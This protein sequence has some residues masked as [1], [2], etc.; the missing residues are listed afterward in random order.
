MVPLT[1]L[2]EGLQELPSTIRITSTGIKENLSY[3]HCSIWGFFQAT[4]HVTMQTA[5]PGKNN[6]VWR[7][8]NLK[9][10]RQPSVSTQERRLTICQFKINLDMPWQGFLQKWKEGGITEYRKHE[11]IFSGGL[12]APQW[13]VAF[14]S[15][16]NAFSEH[17]KKTAQQ[18]CSSN[19]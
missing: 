15:P 17:F 14:R 8:P 19:G 2:Q 16:E 18:T 13:K 9:T 1:I 3:Y 6:L 4:R 5:V 12:S 7:L 11:L 10:G